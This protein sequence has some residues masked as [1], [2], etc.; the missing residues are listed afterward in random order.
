M[1]TLD[2]EVY[3]W[4]ND[5]FYILGNYLN[6]NKP[7]PQGEILVG[8]GNVVQGYYKKPELTEKDFTVIDGVNYFCTGD[9]GQFESDGSLRVIGESVLHLLLTV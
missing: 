5:H 3:V 2:V 9:I 1:Y 8:G 4:Y 7:Y 6:T